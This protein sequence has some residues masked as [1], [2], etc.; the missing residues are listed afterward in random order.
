MQQLTANE[1]ACALVHCN[2][3]IITCIWLHR[4]INIQGLQYGKYYFHETGQNFVVIRHIMLGRSLPSVKRMVSDF[5]CDNLSCNWWILLNFEDNDP[6]YW[7]KDGIDLGYCN[8]SPN[9]QNLMFLLFVQAELIVH[10]I[11]M[12]VLM[13]SYRKIPLRKMHNYY[14]FWHNDKRVCGHVMLHTAY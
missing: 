12:V 6:L 7:I 2:C 1:N 3:F 13:N 14:K 5:P 11:L 10:L 4:L 9:V 8:S